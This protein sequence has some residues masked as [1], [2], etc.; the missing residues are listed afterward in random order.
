MDF[1]PV[2]IDTAGNVIPAIKYILGLDI[3]PS[4]KKSRIASVINLVGS[5]FYVQ[6]FDANSQVFD[7]TAIG[8]T[9]YSQMSTQVES[10]ATK[11][12][13]QYSL[14]RV[15]DPIVK[16]FYDTALGKAQEEAFRNAI[17]LDK[18]PTLTRSL[19]GETCKWCRDLVG[20]HIYPEGK[21]FARHDNC[22]CL[23]VVSGYNTRNGVL[24]NYSKNSHQNP[25]PDAVRTA[26]STNFSPRVYDVTDLKLEEATPGVGAIRYAVDW[27]EKQKVGEEEQEFASWLLS[28]LGGDITYVP[29]S[30]TPTPDYIWN[31][32]KAELKTLTT[33]SLNQLSKKISEAATQSGFEGV[34]FLDL[35]D[36]EELWIDEVALFSRIE[37]DLL[38]FEAAEILVRR[39]NQLIKYYK[40]D[41]P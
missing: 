19:V 41:Y 35:T 37:T 36:A 5:D 14:D 1:H 31:D 33:K 2:A 40:K 39:G 6:M 20:T 26:S 4:D 27:P 18:H 10:L 30:S 9:D 24:S 11:I 29:R 34:V 22:D 38:R 23:I 15:I 7:S 17:S 12:V 16:E 21:Y 28:T 13:R 25:E 3:S 8:T 32:E